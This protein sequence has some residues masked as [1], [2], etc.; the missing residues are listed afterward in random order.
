LSY[1]YLLNSQFE[2]F[3]DVLLDI[4]NIF[5]KSD[6][7]IH[8]ARNELKI[9]QYE[10]TTTVIKAFRI[11][12]F[13]N[14]IAYSFVRDS[15]AKRS[16][17]YSL[18]IEEFVPK[19]I[20]YIEFYS[21]FLLKESYFISENFEFDFTIKEPIFNKELVN[22]EE[23]LRAFARFSFSLH[24]AGIYHNDY[25]PGNILVKRVED[26]YIFKIVDINRMAF[27]TLSQDDRAKNFEK[28]WADEETLSVIASE[29]QKIAN[30]D[31]SFSKATID[32]THK[33][34]ERK[35]LKNRFKGRKDV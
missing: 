30:F 33:D 1:K 8:K 3:K 20:G 35:R 28:L 26:K 11:P 22:R 12:N 21:F 7:S 14:Q 29:Y 6:I 18:K 5:K 9:F 24:E 23:I 13:I 19:P 17:L 34:R 32:F 4:K 10:K 2:N 31:D 15:K 27:F 16:F 25:S